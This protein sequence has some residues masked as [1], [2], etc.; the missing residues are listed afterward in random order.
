MTSSKIKWVEVKSADMK[1][2][3]AFCTYTF[4]TYILF[5][6]SIQPSHGETQ[7]CQIQKPASLVQIFVY[8]EGPLAAL[9]DNHIISTHELEGNVEFNGKSIS[10]SSL[11]FVVPVH[12]FE[13]DNPM[14][15]AQAG[16]DFESRISSLNR[17]I[18]RKSM[19]SSKILDAAQFPIIKIDSQSIRKQENVIVVELDVT[20][21]GQSRLETTTV[22][23]NHTDHWL[24]LAGQL[25]INQSDYGITPYRIAFGGIRVR[26]QLDL[27]FE[28]TAR[29]NSIHLTLAS[30]NPY[31]S[32]RSVH[33]ANA[34]WRKI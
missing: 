6:L 11:S 18:T 21:H 27:K 14:L 16:K 25:S 15:R 20:L 32:Y 4:F 26:E 7:T 1:K 8:S 12:S 22:T 30:A 13:V 10:Q 3:A 9:G 28:I 23:L 17:K 24:T 5:I 19:L 31:S 34:H 2:I 29:C 33:E